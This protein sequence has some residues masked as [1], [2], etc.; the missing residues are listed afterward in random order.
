MNLKIGNTPLMELTDEFSVPN[1]A[2]I[3]AKLETENAGGSIKD[4]VALAIVEDAEERGLLKQG[5]IIVEATSGNTGIGLAI[6]AKA[7]GYKSVIFM[8]ENSARS[9]AE[10]I[11]ACGGEVRLTPA[12]EG[13]RGSVEEAKAFLENTPNGYYADQFNNPVCALAHTKTT[14][15]EIWEQ[16]QG[17]ADIFVAGVGTGGTLTGVSRYLKQKNPAVLA[18]GVEPFSSPLLSQGF[19]GKH[20]IQGIGANFIP[21]VLDRS[22]CDEVLTATDEEAL[23]WAE[24]LLKRKGLTVGLSSGAAFSA[25][26]KLANRE[27]NAGKIIVTVFQ[28]DGNRYEMKN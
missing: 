15:V 25:C 21:S 12:A 17:K 14:G 18:V 1:G 4:R 27:E 24:E 22:V 3:F 13:M 11:R 16:T 19:S 5:G 10:R 2:R 7:K 20:G 26:L 9:I 23:Y 28:Y 8:P 6:V